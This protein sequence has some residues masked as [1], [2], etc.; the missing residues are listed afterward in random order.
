M[1][2]TH[3][4]LA[5]FKSFV[6]PTV[7][8][9]PAQLTGVVGP[10]GCGKSNVID[11]VRWVLGESSAKNLRGGSMQDVIFNGS[12]TRKPAS[13]A[14]V[15]LA[16]NNELGRAAG[17]W[18]QYAE[19]SVKR[20][21]DR[22]GDSTFYINNL[23]VRRR[24]VADLFLG[25]GVGARAYAIIEQGMISRLIEAKP[26]ELRGYLEEAAGV[27][28]YKERRKE[29]ESRLKDARDNMNRVEDIQR[30]LTSQ[31]E[32]LTAQA[33]VAKHYK[34]LQA[35]LTFSQHR[36]WYARKHDASQ[37]RA[38]IDKDLSA[39]ETK[40]EAETARLRHIESLLET[41][42]QTQFAGQ[43]SLNTQ[44]AAYYQA[45]AEVARIEQ[46]MAHQN[47]TRERLVRQ[48]Q[49]SSARLEAQQARRKSTADALEDVTAEQPSLQAAQEEAE[50]AARQATDSTL[51]QK[52]AALREAQQGV[53]EA[54]RVVSQS[55]QARQ[56]D[57]NSLGHTRRQIEQLD[58]RKQ[59]LAQ[60]QAQLP[61]ADAAGLAQKQVELD[62]LA[63]TL[64]TAQEGL[65]DAETALPELDAARAQLTRELEAARK[66]LHQTE[67]ELAALKKL[68][69]SLKADEKLAAWLRS[70]G[71]D[72]APR[73]WES[74]RVTPGWEAAVEAVLRERL[75]A[76]AADPQPD[77]FSDAPPARLTVWAGQGAAAPVTPEFLASKIASDDAGAHAALVVWLA[78]VYWADD[79][80]AA[81]VRS[82]SLQ[83]GECVVTPQGHLFTRHSVTFHG[84]HTAVEGILARGRELE[85]LTLDAERLHDE[86]AQFDAA[87]AEAQHSYAERQREVQ[88]LRAQTGQTQS[89]HHTAQM[90][91]LRLQQAVERVLSRATQISQELEEVT[92]LQ[93]SERATL[94][95]LE[96]RL[97]DYRAQ[98]D[99]ARD[100]LNAARQK[101][102]QADRAVYEAR[103]LQ[104]A[105]ERR[106]QEAGFALTTCTHKL[107]E[108]AAT[109]ARIEQ[110]IATDETRLAQTRDELAH[111]PADALDIE[112]QQALTTRTARETEL[113]A[114]R[115]ALES[116]TAQL[117]SH[118]EAR[119]ACEQGLDPLR[120]SIEQ[121]KLKDQEAMLMQSQFELQLREAAADEAQLESNLA[122]SPKPAQLQADI[123]RLQNEVAALGAVNLA[124]LDELTQAQARADYLAAQCADLLEAVTTLEDAIRRIDQE[125][126]AK[127]KETFDT[128]NRHMGELFPQLFGGGQARLILTGDELLDSG[129]QVF[130]QPPG[131]K[132]ASIQMLSGGEKTLTALSLVFAMFKLNPAPFCLLDEVDAP[133]DD[134]NTDRY[135]KL[136]KAMSDHTQFLFITHNRVTMEMAQHLAGVTM[137][138]PGVS[139]I[140]AVD[141]EQAVGMVEAA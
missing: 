49:E 101:R 102:D 27:S 14:S 133:L 59:R 109:L 132:N 25:T 40:L 62:A 4:K 135:C 30:E 100:A 65:K 123:T 105:A 82:A 106:H 107:T 129:V 127:L 38:R 60:E 97:K 140:V 94:D 114:A 6:D 128:V 39:A 121:L 17:Q 72:R 15:E 70:R 47:A 120:R 73:L 92:R 54:Q 124:A 69:E 108:L 77:W 63:Q 83:A 141:V 139:R 95:L 98:G 136:V 86:V 55:E 115:D 43:D 5:G 117:R 58:T 13:R 125:S 78:G 11:A 57:E 19:I 48:V 36:L 116:L 110:E 118:D 119:L 122:D 21:L 93:A 23:R 42:R 66:A 91:L 24:D 46:S 37:Q 20:M 16:F 138:E 131:K 112:L 90:E 134:A 74:L 7:I 53:G 96:S 81:R 8:P 88:A 26:E 29:T 56:V 76:V 64:A 33:E 10:N 22:S 61:R 68:Q 103:E 87:Y 111:M 50:A 41:A 44:Q 85:R 12:A 126:R 52:E 71:L 34:Q 1:R 51:P 2:L 79:V 80:D 31:V 89:R 32:K 75:Q 18:S 67:A 45:Q 9:V 35:D 104:R 137:Q 28:K 84:P 99:A 130:A 3:I 113:A